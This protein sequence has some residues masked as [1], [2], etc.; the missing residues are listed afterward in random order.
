MIIDR[1]KAWYGRRT[2]NQRRKENKK[3]MRKNI[4]DY[5]KIIIIKYEWNK[6]RVHLSIMA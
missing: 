3:K 2:N 5:K 1:W 6:K 4:N